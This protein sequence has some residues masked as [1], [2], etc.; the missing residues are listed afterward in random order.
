[1]LLCLQ[2]TSEGPSRAEM[3]AKLEWLGFPLQP[4][5]PPGIS[6]VLLLWLLE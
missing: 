2:I 1:M 6:F 3:A 5:S 4:S